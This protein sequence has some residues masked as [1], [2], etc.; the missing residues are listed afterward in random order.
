MGR[1]NDREEMKIAEE[2]LESFGFG[3][4]V[5]LFKSSDV[6][7]KR[8]DEVNK[9]IKE[10]LESAGKKRPHV[11]FDFSIS[12]LDDRFS[13]R[14]ASTGRGASRR[15]T[16]W[17][18]NRMNREKEEPDSGSGQEL[19]EPLVDIFEDEENLRVVAI[20][21][22]VNEK[23]ELRIDLEGKHLVLQTDKNRKEVQLDHPVVSEP[24]VRFKNGIFEIVLAKE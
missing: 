6:F 5:D 16:E 12:T 8:M 19:R 9:H 21:P 20:F 3:G 1:K 14:K 18:P 15:D 4:L 17:Q 7:R 2:I 10:N 13:T 11:D 24:T 23:E 22:E